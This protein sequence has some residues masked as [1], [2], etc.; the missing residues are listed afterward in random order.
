[1]QAR[2]FMTT[3][4]VTVTP[5]TSISEA[6]KLLLDHDVTALPVVGP[7]GGLV[8]IV[9]RS[10]L[11][12]RRVVPDPRAHVIPVP[13][14]ES[15]PP[16]RVGD[17][18]TR[19]VVALPPTADEEEAAK[20]LL[21]HRVKSVPVVSGGRP[22]G[23]VSVTDILRSKVRGDA[24]IARDVRSRLAEFQGA[25]D[26]WSVR[27]DDGMVTVSGSAPP[28]RRR[29]ALLL[30]ETVPGVVRV[31]YDDAS[32]PESP[33]A[34][35]PDAESPGAATDRRGLVVLGLDECLRRLATTPVGRVAFVVAGA[36]IVLP[37]NHGLDGT[38]I[39][40]RTTW[41]SKLQ[42]AQGG[43]AVAFEVDGFEHTTRTG[44]SVL[45][46]GKASPVYESYDV[47]RYDAL[48]VRPWAGI[49]PEDD[50][51]WIRIRAEEITGREILP[52]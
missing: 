45:V 10:D 21:E 9:S 12:Q 7:D 41:G 18:M 50:A 46:R 2:E 13:S 20:A 4:V 29:V 36:P 25:D 5:E 19:T 27:V 8:G 32:D 51:V 37:V 30:A 24:D 31:R 34:E 52:R 6:G 15:E 23:V 49:E 38:S 16:H 35:S 44:W 40:F 42:V 39:V 14:D 48:G 17:V 43:G 47:Q 11:I 26:V 28:Q 1:M 3:A 33:D 22:V